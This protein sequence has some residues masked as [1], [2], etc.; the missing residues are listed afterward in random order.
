VRTRVIIS[1]PSEDLNFQSLKKALKL[2]QFKIHLK[3][4]IYN[5]LLKESKGKIRSTFMEYSA[6]NKL[7]SKRTSTYLFVFEEEENC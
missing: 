3:E 6:T 1:N 5:M 4:N 7:L 2:E